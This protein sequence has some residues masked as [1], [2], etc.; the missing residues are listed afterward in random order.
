MF[1]VRAFGIFE[2]CR[3]RSVV[4]PENLQVLDGRAFC[5]GYLDEALQE[6]PG[7]SM[8]ENTWNFEKRN[9]WQRFA[10]EIRRRNSLKR[11]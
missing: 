4:L 1:H 8:I 2:H 9:N 5:R 3:L 10:E 6:I 11:I 7:V